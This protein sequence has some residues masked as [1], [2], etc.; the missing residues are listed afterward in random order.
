MLGGMLAFEYFIAR[1]SEAVM[2]YI[3]GRLEDM[4]YGKHVIA[5]MSACIGGIMFAL[6]SAYHLFGGG[7]A[8]KKFRTSI[9]L[10]DKNAQKQSEMMEFTPAKSE[11]A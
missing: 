9:T 11:I 1:S 4:G 7:A 2:S 10:Y 5:S 3:T 8:G 6:W